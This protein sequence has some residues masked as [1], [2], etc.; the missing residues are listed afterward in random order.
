M[1]VK[2]VSYTAVGV[3]RTVRGVVQVV[4]NH[5]VPVTPMDLPQLRKWYYEVSIPIMPPRLFLCL[6]AEY[7]QISLVVVPR[8]HLAFRDKH[9]TRKHG[10]VM[11]CGKSAAIS[12][13][14][15]KRLIWRRGAEADQAHH[16]GDAHHQGL[17][18]ETDD[19]GH[20]CYD[21]QRH[22]LDRASTLNARF[23]YLSVDAVAQLFGY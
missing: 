11:T 6:L 7:W 9:F 2:I 10:H 23:E 4:G 14:L 22:I 16:S 5:N 3:M 17:C 12:H 20:W 13:S 21:R 18:R 19:E 1:P 8:D 15:L